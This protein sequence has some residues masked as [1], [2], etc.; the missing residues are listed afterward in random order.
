MQWI[1]VKDK[2]PEI[3]AD[4]SSDEVLVLLESQKVYVAVLI[5]YPSVGYRKQEDYSWSEMST[6]CGCCC[7]RLVPTHWM[8]I[9]KYENSH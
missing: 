8:E 7:K 9:P 5:F 6:G 3:N 1:S 2:L 4:D